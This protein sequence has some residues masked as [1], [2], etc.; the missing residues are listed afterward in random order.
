M[1]IRLQNRDMALIIRRRGGIK[2]V[3]SLG[4]L[5]RPRVALNEHH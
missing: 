4:Y 3:E 1:A 2:H 5:S